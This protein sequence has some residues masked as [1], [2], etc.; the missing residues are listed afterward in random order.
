MPRLRDQDK[1]GL[2]GGK[3]KSA[4]DIEAGRAA[5]VNELME[6][7]EQVEKDMNELRGQYELFFMGVERV[8]PK[9]M[10]DKLRS[11]LRRFKELPNLNTAVKFKFQMLQARLISLES[12]WGRI[13]RQ[14]E[15]GT[16]KRDVD[17]V[18]R[19]QAELEAEAA[20]KAGKKGA[21]TVQQKG[22]KPEGEIL[23]GGP[24]KQPLSQAEPRSNS[25]A[26]PQA[27]IA[28]PVA[29]RAEDLSEPALKQLYQ[30][31]V[32]AKRRC[33]EQVDLR[34]DE[35]A[36]SLKKQV[37]K[38]LQSTGAKSV[39]FKVVIKGGHAV[40]KAVPKT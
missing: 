27:G 6:E 18:K 2:F 20:K 31:Y 11:Q 16:Y 14:K 38:L 21:E 12:H 15:E 37:P 24:L 5:D 19:K 3:G 33:G 34:Y 32:T 17:R 23:P 30:T 28:R 36:A 8:E 1:G 40:L 26:P 7:L 9:P 22:A 35:M 39:E 4:A 25:M 29:A 13:T 10:R